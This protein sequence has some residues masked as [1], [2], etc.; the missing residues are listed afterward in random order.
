MRKMVGLAALSLI[1]FLVIGYMSPASNGATPQKGGDVIVG[2]S[3]EPT[4]FHPLTPGIEVDR[5]VHMAIFDPLWRV[6][7][8]GSFVPDLATQI[9]SVENGGISKD[10]LR[11]TFRLRKDAVWHDGNPFTAADVKFTYDLIMNPSFKAA[12]RSGYDQIASL[13]TPDQYT[14]VL[15][16]KKP[17]APMLALWS[18][19]YIVPQHILS[20]LADINSNDFNKNPIGTG[21]FKFVE[22]VPGDHITLEA[23]R[24]YHG[25]GPYLDRVI[26]KYIPDLTVMFVR[27]KTG[28]IDVTGIQGITVDHYA[29]AKG[30]PGVKLHMEP[31]SFVEYIW[32]NN[33]LPQ[34]KDKAV[35]RALYLAMNK[36]DY[37]ERVYYGV[38]PPAES[39]LAPASW[40]FNPNLPK[41]EYNVSK[42]KELLDQAGWKPGPDGIRQKDGVKLSFSNS[43]TAGNKVREQAQAFLQQ[44]WKQIG[45]NMEIKNMPAAVVW[46]DYFYKSQ[47]DSVMV[48]WN[49]PVAGDPNVLTWFHSAFI[50]VKTGQGSNTLQY[51]NTEVDK[52][53]DEGVST[54]DREKRKQ[55]YQQVQSI[56]RDDMPFLTVF[57]YVAIEGTK[58]KLQNYAQ[59]ANVWSNMWNV[60]EWWWEK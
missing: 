22:R 40:A 17:F 30:V 19:T 35:R 2:L 9:P 59:N 27:F 43:T 53:L 49:M 7:P 18:D 33:A 55:I 46:G 28:A 58:G 14:V 36:Q 57:Y 37:V 31:T 20:Q 41:H 52:L 51:S 10:G 23:N 39:F 38:P 12:T 50:P 48:G 21:A 26:F 56:I 6:D 11:F 16:L 34:F 5:G 3:Q 1:V 25:P 8:R 32:F 15:T 24:R 13:S 54:L 45:V 4:V 47:F 44:G 60:N 42:A 29:E